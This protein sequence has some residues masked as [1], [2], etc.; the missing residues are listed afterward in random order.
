MPPEL[1]QFI[2]EEDAVVRLQ[3]LARHGEV[4]AADQPHI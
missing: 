3:H 1:R 4:P 2:Q